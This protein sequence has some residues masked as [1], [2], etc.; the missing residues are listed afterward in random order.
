MAPSF[1]AI[2]LVVDRLLNRTNLQRSTFTSNLSATGTE[3][4]SSSS[5]QNR[6]LFWKGRDSSNPKSCIRPFKMVMRSPPQ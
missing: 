1:A 2:G 5:K 3:A 6:T 4:P